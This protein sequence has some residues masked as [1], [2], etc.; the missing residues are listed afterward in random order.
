MW[1]AGTPPSASHST[2]PCWTSGAVTL[3]CP[4][5]SRGSTCSMQG[6]EKETSSLRSS[7]RMGSAACWIP[8]EDVSLLS[9]SGCFFLVCTGA[10]GP[11]GEQPARQAPGIWDPGQR[12]EMDLGAEPVLGGSASS[13]SNKELQREAGLLG[14]ECPTGVLTRAHGRDH[15]K[16]QTRVPLGRARLLISQH[17]LG[18]SRWGGHSMLGLEAGNMSLPPQGTLDGS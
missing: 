5:L 1:R 2:A 10:E 7:C 6:E 8:G 18:R 11:G 13:S 4:Q 15:P 17:P 9:P 12:S 16:S 3:I 14:P